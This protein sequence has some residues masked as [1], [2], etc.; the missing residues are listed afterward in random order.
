MHHDTLLFHLS[1]I[2]F[3][4]P[5]IY[6]DLGTQG[7]LST[8]LKEF[9][10]S[11]IEKQLLNRYNIDI[12]TSKF[13]K[14]LYSNDIRRFS[15]GVW[16]GYKSNNPPLYEEKLCEMLDKKTQIKDQYLKDSIGHIAKERKKQIIISLDNSDQR[17]FIIQQDTFIIGHELAKE[18]NAAVFL[19]VRPFTFYKS[20]QA[21]AFSAYPSK[22]FT[23]LPPRIDDLINKRLVFALK[24]AEGEIPV[25]GLKYLNLNTSNISSFLKALIYSLSHN[26]DISELLTNITGGNIRGV[27]DV[28]K[29]FIGSP[30]VDAEK[31]ISIMENNGQYLIPIHEFSKS[32]LLGEYSHFN[33][34]SS[35]AYNLFDVTYPDKKEHFLSSII[36]SFLFKPGSTFDK[37]LF[38]ENDDIC[39]EMQNHGFTPEQVETTLSKL[40]NK[41]L[42]ENQK[43]ITHEED[44]ADIIKQSSSKYRV[45]SIGV[46][47]ITKWIYTFSYLDAMVFDTPIFDDTIK[48]EL[49]KSLESFEITHRFNRAFLFK[50]YLLSCWREIPTTPNYFNFE[51]LMVLSDSTFNKVKKYIESNS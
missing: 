1:T 13:I 29:G 33:P 25:I 21:G 28:V 2:I 35:I 50:K 36:I 38:I 22:V 40:I 49:L 30:N 44:D 11:E 6:I 23:I 7:T 14:G 51:E 47:H 15:S 18:W 9:V 4:E 19:S 39:K 32:A 17:D 37:N 34:D 5:Y 41:R 20:K 43:R 16:G 46:Y 42:I 12:Y 8:T 45:T 31:I 48:D 26:P 27:I 3:Q 10:L 24:M